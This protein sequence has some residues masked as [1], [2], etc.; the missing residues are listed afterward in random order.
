MIIFLYGPDSYRLKQNSRIVLD[1]YRKKHSDGIFFK[2]DLSNIDEIAKAEDAVKS[3]SLF[4]EIKLIVIKNSFFNKAGS[5]RM[6]NLIKAQNLLKEKD[7]VLLFVE[8]Q[9]EKELA[10]NKTLFNLLAGKD[11]MVKN[12]EYLEGEKLV[13]WIRGEFVSRNCLIEP[14]AIKEL[15]ITR[16]N[17]SWALINEIEKL[18][19]YSGQTTITKKDVA[20][21]GF[22]KIDL[23]I[24]D[25]V[26][27]IA[28]KNKLKAYEILFKE[29]Q[30]GRDPYYLLTMIVYGFR[31]LLAVKD[32]SARGMSLSDITKRVRLHPFVAKKSYQSADRFSLE[33]LRKVYGRL[34]DLDTRSKEGVLNLTDSLFSF[35]LI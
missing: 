18:S 6:G 8:N 7:T 35:V 14:D 29:I 13:K 11:S 4:G 28:G 21:L 24:F 3:G 32:L 25:F 19:N 31:N 26:D 34:L 2:F 15:V 5:D 16:G 33:E 20:L 30:N 12:I 23:N 10:K 1:N 9:D 22:K 27:A 17:D